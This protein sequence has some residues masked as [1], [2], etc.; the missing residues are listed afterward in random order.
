[1]LL[2]IPARCQ[3]PNPGKV[4]DE[5][6]QAQPVGCRDAKQSNAV[7][8]SASSRNAGIVGESWDDGFRKGEFAWVLS[9]VWGR[10]VLELGGKY[11]HPR[12]PDLW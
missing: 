10:K 12:F 2:V 4:R 6:F 11:S 5:L 8:I 1:M 7:I 3:S 9:E